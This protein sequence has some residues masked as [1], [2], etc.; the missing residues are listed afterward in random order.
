MEPPDADRHYT[1]RLVRLPNLS[2]YYEP[3]EGKPV[4]MS[5]S[6]LAL[7]RDSTMFWCGQSLFKC[8]PQFDDVFARI[9]RAAPNSQFVFLRHHGV[10]RVTTL[11]QERLERA[12][13]GLGLAA[14]DHC[15]FLDRLSPRSIRG[16]GRSVRRV[17]AQHWL[18]RVQFDHG[19]RCV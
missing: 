8:R 17:F 4:P 5:R 19:R 14:S 18:V 15:V 16:G 10:Q 6:E 2:V 7:R 13:S 11:F 9:A 12:F 1:E 3:I